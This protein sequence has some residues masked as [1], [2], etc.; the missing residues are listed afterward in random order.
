MAGVGGAITGMNWAPCC[1][2]RWWRWPSAWV[3][4]DAT[5]MLVFTI[6]GT[7]FLRYMVRCLV[8]T[9]VDVGRGKM[10]PEDF[11]QILQTRDRALAGPSAPPQGLCLESVEYAATKETIE[12]PGEARTH[13]NP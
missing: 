9:M 3:R 4:D 7:G 5:R 8:G 12:A 13:V 6:R 2:G 1:Q 10:T 11:G